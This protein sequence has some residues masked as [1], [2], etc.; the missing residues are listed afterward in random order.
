VAAAKNVFF[1]GPFFFLP[2]RLGLAEGT[3]ENAYHGEM[4]GT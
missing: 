1:M 2:S 3:A 4:N